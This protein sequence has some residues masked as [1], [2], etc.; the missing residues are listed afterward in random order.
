MRRTVFPK[1]VKHAA[2]EE[3]TDLVRFT[4]RERTHP[5]A[6][7]FGAKEDS[8]YAISKSLAVMVRTAFR[9]SSPSWGNPRL[10]K[11]Q[12]V[13]GVGIEAFAVVYER[14]EIIV[15]AC[16]TRAWMAE[17]EC[18]L[19]ARQCPSNCALPGG[20][21]AHSLSPRQ[22]I[23]GQTPQLGDFNWKSAWIRKQLSVE[24]VGFTDDCGYKDALNNEQ[25]GNEILGVE[26]GCLDQVA[27]VYC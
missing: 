9:S 19:A 22:R 11:L 4:Y 23:R 27:V 20:L 1:D 12:T 14:T 5:H 8:A 6:T 18:M 24:R 16:F 10:A 3:D 13:P 25:F 7:I 21:L 26:G 15:K 17:A 2:T